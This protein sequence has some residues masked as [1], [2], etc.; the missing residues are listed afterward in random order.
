MGERAR[1][2]SLRIGARVE[3]FDKANNLWEVAEVTRINR[4]HMHPKNALRGIM[5]SMR[6]TKLTYDVKFADGA[7]AGRV[8]A[9]GIKFFCQ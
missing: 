7:V 8:P 6:E 3:V 1:G 9:K 5:D 4:A 2:P